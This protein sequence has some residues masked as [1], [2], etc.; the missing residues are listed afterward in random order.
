MSEIVD[1]KSLDWDAGHRPGAAEDRTWRAL[2]W[3]GFSLAALGGMAQVAAI[4]QEAIPTGAISVTSLYGPGQLLS[5]NFAAAYGTLNEWAAATGQFRWLP[6]WLYINLLFDVLFITGYAFLGFTLLPPKDREK[7]A[8]WLL[9]ALIA[10]DLAED[11]IAAVAFFGLTDQRHPV[12]ALAVALHVA[13]MLKWLAALALLVRVAYRAWDS[14]RARRAI[15]YLFSALWEQRFSVVVVIFLAVVAAGSG[16]DVLEQMPDVQRSWLT[17]PPGMG[18]V[19]AAVA[20]TAQLLLAL[21]AGVPGPDAYLAGQGE[22]QR[23]GQP[24]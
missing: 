16:A 6:V 14:K 9:W 15:R 8:W 2:T 17:W 13:T 3:L 1:G 23:P 7:P 5:T 10:A 18:W 22:I 4:V 21:L 20:V 24:P 19:H 12:Y 11:A